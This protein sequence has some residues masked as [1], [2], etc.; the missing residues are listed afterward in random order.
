MSRVD[1]GTLAGILLYSYQYVAVALRY[2]KLIQPKVG[3]DP[4]VSA[5]LLLRMAN[6]VDQ[7]T[8]ATL[9]TVIR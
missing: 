5:L 1:E 8:A 3:G 7:T 2:W 6:A 9:L 4:R